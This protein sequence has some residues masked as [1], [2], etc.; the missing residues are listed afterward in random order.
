MAVNRA[1]LAVIL[2]LAITGGLVLLKNNLA[3]SSVRGE[4]AYQTD[5]E[6]TEVDV[7]N[8]VKVLAAYIPEDSDSS[9]VVFIID[10]SS[11]SFDLSGYDIAKEAILA[12]DQIEPLPQ[13]TS[14]ILEKS[15]KKI[16]VRMTYQEDNRSHYHLLVKNLAGISDRVLHFYLN[17]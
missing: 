10:V 9:K 11:D 16:V 1:V 6:W 14:Q 12:D 5:P 15:A 3:G 4:S 8:G 13:G 2:V 17:Q 7:Q